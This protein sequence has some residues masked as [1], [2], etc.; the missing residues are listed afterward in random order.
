MTRKS[1]TGRFWWVSRSWIV[2]VALSLNNC[3]IKMV[4]SKSK[5]S[6]KG[7]RTIALPAVA[8][9][10]KTTDSP[11][12]WFWEITVDPI[13]SPRATYLKQQ[14]YAGFWG[15]SKVPFRTWDYAAGKELCQI[16]RYRR[17][18]DMHGRPKFVLWSPHL[19]TQNGYLFQMTMN[20][21]DWKSHQKLGQKRLH[22]SSR[23]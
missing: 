12:V 21:A 16:H 19:P 14:R 7:S 23:G 20:Y 11:E 3:S 1:R 18:L 5:S 13:P 4:L 15:R 17:I 9:Q 22:G 2:I 8:G 10:G 6:R